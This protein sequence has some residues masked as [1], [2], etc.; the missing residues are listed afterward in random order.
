MSSTKA[1][2]A[3]MLRVCPPLFRFGSRVYHRFNG[4]FHSLSPG[5]MGALDRAFA[6]AS[7]MRKAD[8][9]DYFE[10]GLFRGRT[11]L[12]AAQ[13]CQRMGLSD[14]HCYGFDSF[15]GLP[16]VEGV[17]VA[18]GR[19]FEGQFACSRQEVEQNL[20]AHGLDWSRAT[21]IEGFFDDTLTPEFK[22]SLP[23]RRA[24]VVLLDCD[25]YASTITALEWLEDMLLDGAILLFDDW[26]SY[27]ENEELGQQ[28]ALGEFLEKHPRWTAQPL[29]E[30]ERHG[31]T[32]ML[33]ARGG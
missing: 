10:F 27:G 1:K 7:E 13:T 29:W 26:Y 14:V 2:V 5:A 9:G 31:K 19:F 28:R 11:F 12:H 20:T 22:A 23:R 15:Q 32:F 16:P 8:V 6:K 24:G 25:L 30:F 18:D 3:E 21:L 17:D 33:R 4:G